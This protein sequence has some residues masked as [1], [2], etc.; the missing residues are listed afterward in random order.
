M[1]TCYRHPDRETG[2]ACSS[3]GRPI[4][5]DC[6][7]PTPVGMRCPECAQQKT[8]VRSAAQI[9]ARAGTAAI[10]VTMALIAVNVV[11]YLLEIATGSGGLNGANGDVVTNLA[12]IGEGL[13]AGP[14]GV[15]ELIG[16][17]HGEYWRLVTGGFLHASILH[18]AFNMY[19]LYIVGQLLEPAIGSVRFSVIYAASLFAGSFGS[20]LL[21]PHAI[22]VGASG[23]IF[24]LMG[25]AFFEMRHRGMN[26]FETG[27]GFLIIINLGLG[28]FINNISIGG[29]LGGL[30]GGALAI[31]AFQYGDRVRQPALGYIGCAVIAIASAVAGVAVSD[32]AGLGSPH[33]G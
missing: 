10:P 28:L 11:M 21:E 19:L 30:V 9:R 5:P 27:I 32:M 31:I 29:H 7:T 20:L 18:I 3:C 16:V 22:T 2:V 15:P 13:K 4:C 14:G 26:P 33:I 24:G 12:L 23:A 8:K 17:A 1:A 6:M 25:A